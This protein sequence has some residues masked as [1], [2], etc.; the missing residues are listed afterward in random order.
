M[1]SIGQAIRNAREDAGL[2]QSQL[3]PK[4]KVGQS[5]LSAIERDS[6]PARLE[7]IQRVEKALKLPKGAILRAAG[8]VAGENGASPDLA[9]VEA[10]LRESKRQ[11][12]DLAARLGI[13]LRD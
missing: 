4:I 12:Y 9:A 3:A 13:D 2:T 11:L 1:T 10:Q 7:L 5:R 8:L 6:Y